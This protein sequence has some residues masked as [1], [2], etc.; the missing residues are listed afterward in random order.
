M[1]KQETMREPFEKK[2]T[3]LILNE[4]LEL[5]AIPFAKGYKIK[6]KYSMS[7]DNSIDLDALLISVERSSVRKPI[8]AFKENIIE[9][10]L[11]GR[12]IEDEPIAMHPEPTY[13]SKSEELRK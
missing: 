3:R 6:V 1:D 8:K 4:P 10:D 9:K 5:T 12:L 7:P 2:E 11:G 13:D